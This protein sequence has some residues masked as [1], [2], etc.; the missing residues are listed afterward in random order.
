M[1]VMKE[2]HTDIGAR[3]GMASMADF[4]ERNCLSIEAYC[5]FCFGRICPRSS[6]TWSLNRLDLDPN[7][8]VSPE[9]SLEPWLSFCLFVAGAD[10]VYQN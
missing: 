1:K 6:S 5:L 7:A 10:M 4:K 9:I 3:D 8:E 2:I